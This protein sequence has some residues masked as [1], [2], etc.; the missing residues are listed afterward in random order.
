[1]V[2]C[3]N[4]GGQ[5]ALG[6]IQLLDIAGDFF[7]LVCEN[8]RCSFSQQGPQFSGRASVWH[9]ESPG[10]SPGIST[11]K[12]LSA[13]EDLSLPETL[14]EWYTSPIII[15]VHRAHWMLVQLGPI[16]TLKGS[17]HFLS[18]K[19]CPAEGYVDTRTS[20]IP[21]LFIQPSVYSS[22]QPTQAE[23]QRLKSLPLSPLS[24]QHS[25]VHCLWI[26]KLH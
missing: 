22:I 2:Q 20:D 5:V 23:A 6:V 9:A 4:G 18:R 25:E 15:R 16:R 26:W 12:I 24:N 7:N 14:K 11:E 13:G 8:K 17:W 19:G 10:F 1:M 3:C 21:F